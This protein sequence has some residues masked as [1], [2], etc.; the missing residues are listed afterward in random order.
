MEGPA[1]SMT[2]HPMTI[3]KEKCCQLCKDECVGE[4]YKKAKDCVSKVK[5]CC[6]SRG[7]PVCPKHK[8]LLCQSCSRLYAPSHYEWIRFSMRQDWFR[9]LLISGPWDYQGPCH[10]FFSL[11]KVNK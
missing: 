9:T 5:T 1:A 6:G 2:K 11:C 8:V 4:D 3:E 7:N 10:R